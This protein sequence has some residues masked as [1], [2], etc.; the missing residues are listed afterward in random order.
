MAEFTVRVEL[1]GSPTREQ[2]EAL[3]LRMKGLGFLKTVNGVADGKP[4]IV[5]LPTG[6]YY[7]TSEIAATQVA[8]NVS[9]VANGIRKVVGVFVAQTETWASHP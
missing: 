8:S 2:Y 9:S 7:G 5:R 3:H 4:A 6:L 1:E